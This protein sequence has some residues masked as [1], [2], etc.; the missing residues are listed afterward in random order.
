VKGKIDG[1]II[2]HQIAPDTILYGSYFVR[3]MYRGLG[4]PIGLLFESMKR[5]RETGIL[6]TTWYVRAQ[7]KEI[8]KFYRKLLGLCIM[9]EEECWQSSKM[10]IAQE[11]RFKSN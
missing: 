4:H 7:D 8:K 2:N 10:L 5:Q 1:W 9:S 3:R 6:K 11:E